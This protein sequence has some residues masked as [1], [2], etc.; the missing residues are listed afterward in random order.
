DLTTLQVEWEREKEL[1]K[2]TVLAPD[3]Y[4]TVELPFFTKKMDAWSIEETRACLPSALQ[5]E[6][7]FREVLIGQIIRKAANS[8]D[9]ATIQI[10][11]EKVPVYTIGYQTLGYFLASRSDRGGFRAM[12]AAYGVAIAQ[13]TDDEV[14]ETLGLTL[15]DCFRECRP[16]SLKPEEVLRI[17]RERWAEEENKLFLISV[18]TQVNRSPEENAYDLVDFSNTFKRWKSEFEKEGKPWP[19]K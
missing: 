19:Y 9:L 3:F 18:W 1:R 7:A 12:L 10:C 17:A 15:R 5:M 13:G 14:V 8:G 6:P 16:P 11:L 4:D 2:K